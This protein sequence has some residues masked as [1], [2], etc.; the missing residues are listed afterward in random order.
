MARRKKGEE[1]PKNDPKNTKVENYTRELKVVL[2]P[3]EVAER[4][5]RAAQLLADRD[6]EEAELK[7]HASH[8]KSRIATMESEMRH[9]SGEV[10]TKCTYREVQCERR[11]LYDTGTVQEV[12]LDTGEVLNER[13]MTDREKQRDLPFGGG[14]GSGDID[15]DFDEGEEDAAE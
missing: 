3:E 5:D 11:F 7:A 15:D 6:H 1:P 8:V 9:L 12:R 10:R 2:K 4:A 14:S 13:P